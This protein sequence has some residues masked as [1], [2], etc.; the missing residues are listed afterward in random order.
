[1]TGVNAGGTW[2]LPMAGSQAAVIDAEHNFF[3]VAEETLSVLRYIP[4]CLETIVYHDYCGGPKGRSS[5][6]Q[7]SSEGC[8]EMHA[9]CFSMKH[10][11]FEKI[12]MVNM[13]DSL[14]CLL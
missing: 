10:A 13:K 11:M 4:C 3:S 5:H 6:G 2:L 1:M 9:K 8:R 7:V 14:R 12:S